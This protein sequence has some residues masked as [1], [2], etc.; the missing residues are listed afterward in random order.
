MGDLKTAEA[1]SGR[2]IFVD[3]KVAAQTPETLHLKCGTHVVKVG[4]AGKEQSI[5]VPCGG[6]ISVK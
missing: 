6:E 5:D 3:G 2:R 4:S 1:P